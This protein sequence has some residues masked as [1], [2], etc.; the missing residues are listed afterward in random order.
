VPAAGLT[1]RAGAAPEPAW[2]PR[3]PP[4]VLPGSSCPAHCARSRCSARGS[5][6]QAS[7]L[8]QAG[9]RHRRACK[10][11]DA[12]PGRRPEPPRRRL[13][14]S[15]ATRGSRSWRDGQ[16]DAALACVT[17]A[18][19]RSTRRS[20]GDTSEHARRGDPGAI[21][22]DGWTTKAGADWRRRRLRD[23]LQADADFLAIAWLIATA[24]RRGCGCSPERREAVGAPGASR[25]SMPPRS[26][27]AAVGLGLPGRSIWPERSCS[28]SAPGGGGS[29][30]RAATAR[31]RE[32][33]SRFAPFLPLS[34]PDG[35][36]RITP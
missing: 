10:H 13:R 23:P 33:L 2:S 24:T 30:R 17:W 36:R 35:L 19:S 8:N 32:V 31:S 18:T 14:R 27:V 29:P 9:A 6:R 11:Q 12:P 16:P 4:R 5:S 21:P 1:S 28:R 34:S 15:A 7:A 22:P 26:P 25:W 3:R 20:R